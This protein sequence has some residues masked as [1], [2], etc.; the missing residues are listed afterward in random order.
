MTRR[1]D[2]VNANLR[3]EISLILA[4]EVKN[5]HIDGLVSIVAVETSSD[6]RRAKV[7]VSVYGTG[8]RRGVLRALSSAAGFVGRRLGDRLAMKSVPH[9]QF[10]LDES[11]E[12]GAD[13]SDKILRI[14]DQDPASGGR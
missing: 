2:R 13:L 4:N 10:R 3:Q 14:V 9:L 6:L 12:R 8:D 11:I 7:F 5:P 1:L